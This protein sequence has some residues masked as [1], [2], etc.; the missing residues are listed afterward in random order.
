M[1]DPLEPGRRPDG[2]EVRGGPGRGLAEELDAARGPGQQRVQR[3]QLGQQLL[4]VLDPL[5]V[6][7]EDDVAV[8][9]SLTGGQVADPVVGQ[10]R[11][12]QDQMSG[13]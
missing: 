7:L 2:D 9:Q 4:A 3:F 6:E 12:D 13:A 5:R 11:A 8:D 10:V 1:A